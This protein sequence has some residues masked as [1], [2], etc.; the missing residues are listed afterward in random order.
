MIS[1]SKV[2]KQP[3]T[4]R[5]TKLQLPKHSKILSLSI[6]WGE[7]VVNVAAMNFELPVK[8]ARASTWNATMI[9]GIFEITRKAVQLFFE[10]IYWII[11]G[12]GVLGPSRCRLFGPALG[13]SDLLDFIL[14]TLQALRRCQPRRNLKNPK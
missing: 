13:P 8:F 4:F 14:R 9:K 2:L 12:L 1:L 6:V 11:W 3:E 10:D 5:F 7:E